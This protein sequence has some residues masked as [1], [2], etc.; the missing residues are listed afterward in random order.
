MDTPATSTTD[1]L[2]AG[3]YRLHDKL[4]DGRLAA[5]FHA[6]D[7]TL[8]R[9]VLVHVLRSELASQEPLRQRFLAEIS[10]TARCVHSALLDVFD[11]GEDAGRPYMITE[12]IEGRPLHGQGVQ[13]PER[14]LLYLRQVAG[15]VALCQAHNVPCP[16]ISS[17]NVLVVHE[18]QIKLVENWQ[19]SSTEAAFDL[20]HYRAPELT[21]GEPPGPASVV[22]ALG[23]LL[24]ELMTGS[25]PI[26]G[27]TA[28]EVVRAHTSLQIAPIS[29][30]N[31]RCYMPVLE[32]LVRRATAHSRDQRLASAVEFAAALEQ[33]WRQLHSET[34]RLE[35]P[36]V[37]P[38]PRRIDAGR[39]SQAWP[40]RRAA[41][42][43]QPAPAASEARPPAAA[44]TTRRRQHP[45]VRAA[46][47]RVLLVVL[48]LL[49]A[50]GSYAGASYLADRFFAI[51]LPQIS[52]PQIGL[53]EVNLPHID[54]EVPEW[55]QNGEAAETLIVNINE[56]LNLRDEPG[57]S[58]NVIAVIPNGT[59]VAKLE[60][61]VN[62]DNVPWVRVR[63]ERDNEPVEGWMSRNF[64]Q[65]E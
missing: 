2:L 45:G 11:S 23:L 9:S 37:A 39:F 63:I 60:G 18:G 22:Y 13:T 56:G 19:L 34:Q 44:P 42:A 6:T 59:R 35:A 64:L 3:R 46:T 61:P 49:V 7:E 51:E 24:Y 65:S 48:L 43:P 26:Q 12:Y 62:V 14:A 10:A 54:L 58:T 29:R 27:S 40:L 25:R 4:G 50:A 21:Q 20:A 38:P 15:A 57:L 53:P 28:V 52:M 33:A 17:S 32:T 36:P 55:L 31:P 41:P 30:R 5:V 16:P 8:Q 1:P 47:S